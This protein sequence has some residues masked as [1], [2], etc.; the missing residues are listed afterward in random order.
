MGIL[1]EMLK[2]K[3]CVMLKC[4]ASIS[5]IEEI[6]EADEENDEDMGVIALPGGPDDELDVEYLLGIL[7]NEISMPSTRE[8]K[9]NC[10]KIA[11]LWS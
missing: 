8:R 4:M 2:V 1:K 6:D 10:L 5:D 11:V 3:Q 9:N 7:Q